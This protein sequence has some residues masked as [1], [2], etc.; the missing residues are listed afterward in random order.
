MERKFFES[1]DTESVLGFK[2]VEIPPGSG[3]WY[4]AAHHLIDYV[5]VWDTPADMKIPNYPQ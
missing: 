5:K 3:H 4:H 2:D 1:H